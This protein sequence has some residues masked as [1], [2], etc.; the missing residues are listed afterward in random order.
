MTSPFDIAS[1]RRFTPLLL[2]GV[3][4]FDPFAANAH[5]ARLLQP[6][7]VVWGY[8]D[9][10][11]FSQ[12]RGVAIDP[13]DGAIYVANT[14]QHRIEVFSSGGRPLARFVHRVTQAGGDVVDGSPGAL[15]F[16]RS[17]RLLVVDPRASYVDVLDMRGRSVAR[18]EVAA[19]HPNAVAVGPDGT[20]YVGTAGEKSR[21]HRFKADYEPDGAW[22]DEGTAPGLLFDVM[23]VAP[24]GDTAIA[25]AC[26]RTDVTIQLF[27]PAGRYLGGFGSHEV[28]DGNFSLPTG[29]FASG[30]GRIWVLDDI[31]RTLQIFDREGHFIEKIGGTGTALGAF[32]HPSALAF[33]G[34][35]W[36]ALSDREK[37]R[38]Q[39][40]E[41]TDLQR[42][43]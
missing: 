20:I 4:G 11:A 12:P 18:L 9:G 14:G 29:I 33:D 26:E 2:A 27:T 19:G 41:V 5:A 37:G 34:R 38:V 24:L 15:A 39:V 35:E 32:A 23:A 36:I 16:D 43:P 6:K 13:R 1:I 40:F 3:L 10:V 8:S 17:G 7:L 42:T 30:D 28:G 31:R 25:V 22:G 21:I